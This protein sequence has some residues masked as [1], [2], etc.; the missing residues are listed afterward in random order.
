MAQGEGERPRRSGARSGEELRL[1]LAALS[2]LTACAAPVVRGTAPVRLWFGG[3]VHLGDRAL[4]RLP[5]FGAGVVNLEGPVGPGPFTPERLMNASVSSLPDA[6]VRVAWVENNHAD[7]DGEA[8]RQRTAAALDEAGVAVAGLSVVPLSGLRVVFFGV[9]VSKGVF[10]ADLTAARALG[11]VLVVGFHVLAPPLL[12]PQVDLEVAVGLALEAGAT[13]VV[14]H[15]SHALARVERRGSAVVAWGLGNLQFACPCTK[16][17]DGIV[18][19][20]ELDTSG[21]VG[22]AWVVPVSAGLEGADATLS[23]Q[24]ALTFEL[25]GSLG[26]APLVVD[27]PRGRF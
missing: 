22:P 7:D 1:S 27:G 10:A 9:D 6:G 15:G 23:E 13:V 8:G 4:P 25:L 17:R 3:D 18:L 2:L 5:V 21:Q 11:D 24:P 14:A 20:V 19:E 26:S 16:E 12:L